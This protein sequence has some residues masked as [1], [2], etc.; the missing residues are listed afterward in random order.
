[1]TPNGAAGTDA[2]CQGLVD[3][4]LQVHE[5]AKPAI[6]SHGHTGLSIRFVEEMSV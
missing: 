4:R 6:R 5:E 1:M 3:S 2:P